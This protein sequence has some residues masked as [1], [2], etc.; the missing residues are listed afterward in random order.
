MSAGAGFFYSFDSEHWEFSTGHAFKLSGN[1]YLGGAIGFGAIRKLDV[2]IPA[3]SSSLFAGLRSNGDLYYSSG[4]IFY[5]DSPDGPV[6]SVSFGSSKAKQ[7]HS[8]FIFNDEPFSIHNDGRVMR[9]LEGDLSNPEESFH[10]YPFAGIAGATRIDAS[11]YNI[12][13]RDG[14]GSGNACCYKDNGFTRYS[15][16]A[17]GLLEKM[18]LTQPYQPESGLV[19]AR[20]YLETDVGTSLGILRGIDVSLDGLRFYILDGGNDR[21]YR[22][23]TTTS[24]DIFQL[25]YHSHAVTSGSLTPYGP[26][27]VA[28]DESSYIFNAY[29]DGDVRKILLSVPGDLSAYLTQQNLDI[30]GYFDYL[31]SVCVAGNGLY[32]FGRSDVNHLS[33]YTLDELGDVRSA[34]LNSKQSID[35]SSYAGVSPSNLVS[36]SDDGTR[37]YFN[38]GW[39]MQLSAA[40]DLESTITVYNSADGTKPYVLT[41]WNASTGEVQNTYPI[42]ENIRYLNRIDDT[43]VFGVIG[44]DFVSYDYVNNQRLSTYEANAYSPSSTPTVKGI[45]LNDESQIVS[46]ISGIEGAQNTLY[47]FDGAFSVTMFGGNV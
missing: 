4:N 22:Y 32:I 1:L 11:I 16:G 31:P 20:I 47:A 36:I 39:I 9:Y 24:G 5:R 3:T 6:S 13:P 41:K 8:A 14:I 44:K 28:N 21:V 10:R 27:L 46:A 40:W 23:E 29:D 35:L 19:V 38:N 2:P 43:T 33:R 18:S 26:L 42:D 30:S 15:V 34:N 12:I 7:M 37:L 45:F 17:E 25:A